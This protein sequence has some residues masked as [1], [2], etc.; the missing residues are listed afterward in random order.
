MQSRVRQRE[1][2]NLK[3]GW[4]DAGPE[5]APILFFLH[6]YPDSPETWEF[7]VNYFQ[8]RFR[9]IC[10][11]ARGASPSEATDSLQRHSQDSVALDLLQILN[12]VDPQHTKPIYCIGHDLGA[13]HAWN[14]APLLSERLKGLI[15]LNGLALRQMIGRAKLFPQHLKSWYIYLMN[16][17]YLPE[18]LAAHFAQRLSA[19]AYDLGGLPKQLQPTEHDQSVVVEPIK[20]YRAFTREIPNML[21]AKIKKIEC[22][23]LIL[24]GRK[25]RFLLPPTVDEFE[26]YTSNVTI[27]ILDGN[28]WLH[29]EK[30]EQ[31]NKLIEGF[32]CH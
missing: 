22:P 3:T 27:R 2:R 32:V 9:I 14:I 18:F 26:A 29:R 30:A 31:V 12:C 7:Q 25:D 11:F 5:D 10:P 23:T 24:W 17:P 1:L 20:Q 15:I 19:L 28:H 21:N 6:G 13:V 4:M 16:V 8:D